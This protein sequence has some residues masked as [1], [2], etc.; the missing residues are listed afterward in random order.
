[1]SSINGQFTIKCRKETFSQNILSKGK[2]VKC[3]R[4]MFCQMWKEEILW[5]VN[6]MLH[7]KGS[8]Y[9]TCKKKMSHIK[10]SSV[11]FKRNKSFSGKYSNIMNIPSPNWAAVM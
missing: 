11:E 10:W 3:S 9:V 7:V 1:M 6:N 4:L 5:D 2:Y 8:G